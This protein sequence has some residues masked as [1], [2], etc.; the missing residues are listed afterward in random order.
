MSRAA[1][2]HW[3]AALICTILYVLFSSSRGS[4][5]RQPPPFQTDQ[6]RLCQL[7]RR[8]KSTRV[9]SAVVVG[10]VLLYAVPT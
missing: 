5:N 3:F 4:L 9:V 6:Q 8:M 2:L 1:S 10:A 7:G